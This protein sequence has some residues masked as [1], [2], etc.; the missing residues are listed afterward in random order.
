MNIDVE[1]AFSSYE[2]RFV[3]RFGDKPAGAFV[4]NGKAMIQRLSRGEFPERL[5]AYLHWHGQCRSLLGS[6][7]TISDA[8]VLEFEEASRWLVIEPPDVLALFNGE[9]GEVEENVSSI[10]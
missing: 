2:A 3:E 1:Q 10:A 7:A 6:G 9:I 5:Q 8:L 4:K